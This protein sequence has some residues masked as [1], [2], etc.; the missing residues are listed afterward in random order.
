MLQKLTLLVLL[1]SILQG[2][3][4][5]QIQPCGPNDALVYDNCTDVCAVCDVGLL[6]GYTANSSSW[7]ADNEAG[8]EPFCNGSG[9]IE[10]N[11]WFAFVASS[12]VLEIQVD[13]SN[14]YNSSNSTA[15]GIQ[16][17]ILESPDCNTFNILL[18]YYYSQ[19]SKES[20]D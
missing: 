19:Y 7:T 1:I 14:C 17:A 10:N 9:T 16:A 20:V 6:D 11:A 3:L 2:N 13:Y 15:Q 18:I 5:A 12:D 8:L 4:S